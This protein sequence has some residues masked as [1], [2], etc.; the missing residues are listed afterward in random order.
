[1]KTLVKEQSGLCYSTE[2]GTVCKSFADCSKDEIMLTIQA[3]IEIGR[4]YN[5]NLE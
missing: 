3:C 5:I 4:I 2:E 1:M